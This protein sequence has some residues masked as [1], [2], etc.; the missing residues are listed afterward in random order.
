MLLV[1]L[2]TAALAQ[3]Y[4]YTPGES[5]EPYVNK[6]D[7]VYGTGYSCSTVGYDPSYMCG[8]WPNIDTTQCRSIPSNVSPTP[9]ID[10]TNLYSTNKASGITVSCGYLDYNM[11]NKWRIFVSAN[12]TLPNIFAP[13]PNPNQRGQIVSSVRYDDASGIYPVVVVRCILNDLLPSRI[14]YA[15]RLGPTYPATGSGCISSMS[16]PRYRELSLPRCDPVKF[17][18]R[19]D[20]QTIVDQGASTSTSSASSATPIVT[21]PPTFVG[22]S[23]NM[24]RSPTPSEAP[25]R[26]MIS[27]IALILVYYCLMFMPT[28]L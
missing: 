25:Q 12:G 16:T 19:C 28:L 2:S 17:G 10:P 7:D 15:R 13:D 3:F 14:A 24:G 5:I 21:L 11:T 23:L 20:G 1:L 22:S 27:N 4:M 9:Y 8:T 26:L 6:P 18:A